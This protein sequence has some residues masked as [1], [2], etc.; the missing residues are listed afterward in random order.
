MKRIL[1]FK[2]FLSPSMIFKCT[3]IKSIFKKEKSLNISLKRSSKL[4]TYKSFRFEINRNESMF[5]EKEKK[6][7]HLSCFHRNQYPSK[8]KKKTF[9]LEGKTIDSRFPITNLVEVSGILQGGQVDAS[10]EKIIL[11]IGGRKNREYLA[12]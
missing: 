3:P 5:E 2:F 8:K 12:L 10:R 11:S 1:H 7:S 6:K 9:H 4:A